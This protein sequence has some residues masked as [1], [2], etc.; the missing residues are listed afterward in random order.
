MRLSDGFSGLLIG[1]VFDMFNKFEKVTFEA[2]FS[3]SC[4]V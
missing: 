2:A 1:R 4:L 3:W